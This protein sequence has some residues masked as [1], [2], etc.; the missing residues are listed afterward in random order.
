MSKRLSWKVTVGTTKVQL[1]TSNLNDSVI[2][3]AD[4]DNAGSI[5]LGNDGE[6]SVS[7][8]TGFELQAGE[9]LIF[10]Q[11][12]KLGDIYAIASEADQYLYIMIGKV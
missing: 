2:I 9:Y 11:V 12:G 8:S 1:P 10:D 7:A 3:K 6:D 5:Y 4:T